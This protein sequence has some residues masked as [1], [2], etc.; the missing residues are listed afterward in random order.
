VLL[1]AGATNVSRE[2]YKSGLKRDSYSEKVIIC[3]VLRGRC[4]SGQVRQVYGERPAYIKRVLEKR[5]VYIERV[6][7]HI[8]CVNTVVRTRPR[9]GAARGRCDTYEKKPRKEAYIY[10]TSQ[11]LHT[12]C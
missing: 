6:S 2:T 10:E 9:C 3:R 4:R 12:V 5:L 8:R 11:N 7:S 1:G